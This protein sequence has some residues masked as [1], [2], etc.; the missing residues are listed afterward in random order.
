M[1]FCGAQWTSI[2]STSEGV[3]R[4]SA[5]SR[6]CGDLWALY[7]SRMREAHVHICLPASDLASRASTLEDFVADFA[8]RTCKAEPTAAA[9][10][11]LDEAWAAHRAGRPLIQLHLMGPITDD[12]ALVD[13]ERSR[14]GAGLDGVAEIVLF[15]DDARGDHE[16][17]CAWDTLVTR[18]GEL[19][20]RAPWVWT[21]APLRDEVPVAEREPMVL[22]FRHRRGWV[23]L[24][25]GLADAL[26]FGGAPEGL[27][28][29]FQVASRADTPPTWAVRTLFELARTTARSGRLGD[30]GPGD[31]LALTAGRLTCF[32]LERDP[33]FDRLSTDLGMV[34]VLMA[35]GLCA[36]EASLLEGWDARRFLQEVTSH[37][38]VMNDPIRA[39]LLDHPLL[40]ERLSTLAAKE[41]GGE[42]YVTYPLLRVDPLPGIYSAGGGELV[43]GASAAL[44]LGVRVSARLSSSGQLTAVG[45]H[46]KVTFRTAGETMVRQHSDRGLSVAL[47]PLEV[48]RVTRALLS[49][50]GLRPAFPGWSVRVLPRSMAS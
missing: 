35:F 21:G 40:G 6:M 30:L 38:R 22:G 18:G 47:G 25:C 43:L 50:P 23:L 8:A 27:E 46:S 3:G 29:S 11:A 24:T 16:H 36:D 34:R 5:I 15:G 48:D 2:L 45:P 44:D 31:V 17:L 32:A 41:G 39:S 13:L 10:A 9:R 1:R 20:K 42:A 49:G 33:A 7:D 28:L 4:S 12:A 26:C 19:F 14:M 37:Q